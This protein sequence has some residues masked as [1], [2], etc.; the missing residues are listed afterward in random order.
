MIRYVER[1]GQTY[2][3]DDRIS[4]DG[5]LL[6]QPEVSLDGIT[7]WRLGNLSSRRTVSTSFGSNVSRYHSH[8]SPNSGT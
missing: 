7:Q 4:E 2:Y 6:P 1:Y 3:Y 5:S 8:G